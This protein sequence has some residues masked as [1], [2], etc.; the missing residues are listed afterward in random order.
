MLEMEG[1]RNAI[2]FST[3]SSQSN[4]LGR[5]MQNGLMCIESILCIFFFGG[6]EGVF[7]FQ[8]ILTASF[9]LIGS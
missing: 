3:R 7:K 5:V 8:R 9:L 1:T 6:G 2:I 4:V